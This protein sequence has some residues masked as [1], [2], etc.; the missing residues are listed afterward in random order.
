MSKL[1]ILSDEEF[2]K[3]L[4]TKFADA[5][6]KHDK[7]KV[8]FDIAEMAYQCIN[9]KVRGGLDSGLATQFLYS[10][11]NEETQMPM[12]E[13]LDTIKAVLFLHSKLC[14]SDPVVTGTPRKQDQATINSARYAEGYIKYAKDHTDLQECIESGAYVNLCIYG[15]GVT[16]E[17]WD[18]NGGD[19][20]ISEIDENADPNNLEIKMEGDYD[21]RD[22]S[23]KKWY[24]DANATSVRKMDYCFEEMDVP[25]EEAFYSFP[26]EEKQNILR[27]SVQG[28]EDSSSLEK[29]NRSTVKIYHYWERGRPWNGFLGCHAIF[30]NPDSPRL[31]Y[32]GPNPYKHKKLPYSVL[33][34]IDV[35]DNVM[36]M[37]RIIYA[38]QVQMCINNL[39]TM[40][41]NNA[42]LFG[43]AKYLSPEGAMNDDLDN[44]P[45]VVG[46]YNP[47]TG[48]KPEFF[49][50]VNVTPDVWK[51]YDI[52]KQYINN[53]YGMNEFSQGQIPRE[54]SSYAVQLALEMD[55]KYR[56][57]LFN[58][59]KLFLRD[60]YEKFLEITKQFMT[61]SRRLRIT[62]VEAFQDDEY[63][64]VSMLEG[65]Y[66]ISVEYGA[67]LPVDPA[68]RKQQI[69]E[70]IKSGFFDKAG[71]DYKKAA[72]LLIDGSMITVRDASERHRRRQQAE[73]SKLIKGEK[74]NV[75]PWDKD[76]DHAAEIDE[77]C[78]TAAFEALPREIQQAIWDHGEAHVQ[79][80][81]EKIA[82]GQGP[83]APGAGGP[84]MGG[85]P[86]GPGGA[87][88]MGA[89]G[90]LPGPT[91]PPGGG[92]PNPVTS[93]SGPIA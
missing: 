12:I 31:L 5:K 62:G 64:Q 18:P 47:A 86:A 55:D 19:F 42:A 61:D 87:P 20:P 11:Q 29:E 27:M 54:L 35:P 93:P 51:G 58:K 38:Y 56:I 68:A 70:F 60:I 79:A 90:P 91:P 36:G 82:K 14:I 83:E 81:A 10:P 16:Y 15:T 25:K 76:E 6:R 22:V 84:G 26:E 73:I 37:S 40:V 24:P 7:L 52:M 88:G 50:P 34:D 75:E 65:D 72:S 4:A 28:G 67:Y 32:R 39:I 23:P 8:E 45:S 89:P 2:A 49:R 80:L 43:S 59:K 33:T 44:D 48:G 69:L 66:D 21:L 71:G 46:T 92:E 63:F 1:R 13:G 41:M 74:V 53:I 85:S 57:R 9:D 77:Y 78:G 3:S 17:G 30:T